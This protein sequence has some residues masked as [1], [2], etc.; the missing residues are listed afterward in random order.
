METETVELTLPVGQRDHIEGL[1]TAPV[2]LV[3]YGDYE[4]PYC[5]D[6]YPIIKQVQK[7]LGNKLRFIFRNFPIT[8]IHPHAQ[9]AAEAAEVAAAQN[10]FWEMHDYLYEHQQ[11]LDDNHLEKYAS[12]LG[13]D[14]TQFNL[15]MASHVHAQ[16]VREDFLSG[17]HGGVNGTPTFYINGIRYNGSWNLETLLKTLRLIS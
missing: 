8:Q 11:A 15:D 14:I 13:L 1:N 9:H 3:E 2:T 6:A 16:R 7:N 4:C 10:K 12:R 5:G 17:V